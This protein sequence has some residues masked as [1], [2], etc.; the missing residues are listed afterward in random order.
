MKCIDCKFSNIDMS[1]P[2]DDREVHLFC[3]RYPPVVYTDTD[4]QVHMSVHPAVND[5]GWCGEFRQKE[6]GE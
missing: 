4:E 3:Y 2:E 6:D 1:G 5:D